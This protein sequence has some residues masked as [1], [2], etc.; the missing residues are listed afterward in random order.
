MA[1]AESTLT[2]AYFMSSWEPMATLEIL[3][4]ICAGLATVKL[5]ATVVKS[6]F[7]LQRMIEQNYRTS[8]SWI[9]PVG[10][11]QALQLQKLQT[12]LHLISLLHNENINV[13]NCE[14]IKILFV[15]EL[16]YFVYFVPGHQ[17]QWPHKVV[18]QIF[19]M[20]GCNRMSIC[21]HLLIF[22]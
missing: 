17:L 5:T 14:Q 12:F 6:Y 15:H 22:I 10:C 16:A 1:A 9:S 3:K 4:N 13:M 21:N 19:R 18:L 8:I 2:S 20:Y 7:P 11:L